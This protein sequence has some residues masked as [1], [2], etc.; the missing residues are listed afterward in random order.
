MKWHGFNLSYVG[1]VD[2]VK[3]GHCESGKKQANEKGVWS[4]RI[5]RS[6]SLSRMHDVNITS[7]PVAADWLLSSQSLLIKSDT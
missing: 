4:E 7:A 1:E 6:Y 2:V 3:W 5:L